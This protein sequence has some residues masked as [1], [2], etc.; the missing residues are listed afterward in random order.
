MSGND[1]A[2]ARTGILLGLLL[3]ASSTGFAA[4][5]IVLSDIQDTLGLTTGQGA[6]VVTCYTLGLAVSAPVS[7]RLLDTLGLRRT[8]IAATTLMST[9]ALLGAMSSGFVP[10]IGARLVQGLGAGGL[11]ISAFAS[12]S[13]LF[14]PGQ[15]AVVQGAITATSVTCLGLAPLLGAALAHLGTW[16]LT[17]VA[18][19]FFL[20]VVPLVLPLLTAPRVA[21]GP[22]DWVGAVLVAG[23][24]AASFLVAQGRAMGLPWVA[25][26]SAFVAAV[27]CTISLARHLRHRPHGIVPAVLLRDRR[28]LLLAAAAATC[29]GAYSV[30]SVLVPRL[31]QDGDGWSALTVGAVFLPAA[32]VGALAATFAGRWVES[33]GAA[34]A[35]I[36][37]AP[38][39][40]VSLVVAAAMPAPIGPILGIT[41]GIAVF[42]A[43]QV[44]LF[45]GVPL[46]VP[47]SDRGASMGV[48]NMVFLS[49]ATLC[50]AVAAS[51][52][53]S[54]GVEGALAV[55]A[56]VP[57][58]GAA[59]ALRVKR[60]DLRGAFG[61]GYGGTG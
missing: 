42:A 19:L 14:P 10:L 59:A 23:L 21:Q 32:L 55:L 45:D 60:G 35:L 49:G 25:L 5:P 58:F 38:L 1:L 8:L 41:G 43:G 36:T 50:T 47:P 34:R 33:N 4:V 51:V 29:F 26:A 20:P 2:P 61:P 52:I 40:T 28:V 9:G 16:R 54:V 13:A 18:P 48:A 12:A 24:I 11:A 17:M 57:V 56:P 6:A 37:L 31:L 7:G 44:A 15:T 30:L 22:F 27:V 46:L 39:A 53:S 3:G